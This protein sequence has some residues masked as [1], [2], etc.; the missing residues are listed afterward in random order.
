MSRI[1][2]YPTPDRAP[3]SLESAIRREL[4]GVSEQGMWYD[5]AD[6]STL[7]QDAAGTTPVTAPG[8]PVGLML[9]KSG[10]GNHAFQATNAVRP[11]VEVDGA[12][13]AHLL[14]LG[15]QHMATAAVN[16][17]ASGKV[18]LT[19]GTAFTS[20]GS[21]A[22]MLGLSN[23][24]VS[25]SGVFGLVAPQNMPVVSFGLRGRGTNG[26]LINGAAR[27]VGENYVVSGIVNIPEN[28]RE[29]RVNGELDVQDS[30]NLGTGTFGNYPLYLFSRGGTSVYFRGRFYGA[31]I[32]AGE[33][34]PAKLT[35]AERWMAMRNGVVL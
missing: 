12:D 28:Y 30:G 10:R 14:C 22:E 4:F 2:A 34:D 35:V 27:N 13:N 20:A 18:F 5:P 25:S 24:P 26:N 8:Q 21:F 29:L 15:S 1:I 16:F 33:P 17:T 19:A 11:T 32:R 3:I 9:D 6:F 23:N 7:F 31:I